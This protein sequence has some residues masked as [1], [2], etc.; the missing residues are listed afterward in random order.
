VPLDLVVQVGELSI[1]IRVLLA[2]FELD[3]RLQAVAHLVEQSHHGTAADPMAHLA[4]GIGQLLGALAGPAQ[5]RGR[6]STRGRL[7]QPIQVGD[8]R[9]V[10][11][12]E[13]LAPAARN[14]R[15]SPRRHRTLRGQLL[16]THAD[17]APSDSGGPGH[18]RDPTT[19]GYER[20]GSQ[21]Q[22]TLMFVEMLPDEGEDPRSDDG[23][24]RYRVQGVRLWWGGR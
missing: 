21:E 14:T 20:D 19:A 1:S 15:S 4:Q 24:R 16:L 5:G 13:P 22:P 17:G 12:L 7:D 11:V 6:V 3:V 8:Q 9:G 23:R 2:L 10:G 18:Q